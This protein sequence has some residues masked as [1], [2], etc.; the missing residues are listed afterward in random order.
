MGEYQIGKKSNYPSQMSN[1]QWKKNFI[2]NIKHL[3]VR[4]TLPTE[5]DPSPQSKGYWKLSY[6]TI[7]SEDV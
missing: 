4:R 5:E 7:Y 6:F 3:N 2:H 1:T